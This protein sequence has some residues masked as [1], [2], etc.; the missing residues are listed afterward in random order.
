MTFY[1]QRRQWERREL[2]KAFRKYKRRSKVAEALGINRTHLYNIMR[3]TGIP[4][5]AYFRDNG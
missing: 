2:E 5:R 4:A 1:E 3:R